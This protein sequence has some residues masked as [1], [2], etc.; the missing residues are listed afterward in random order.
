MNLLKI[1]GNT[2]ERVLRRVEEKEFASKH[3]RDLEKLKDGVMINSGD[4]KR[5]RGKKK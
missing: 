3:N 2:L 5:G 4:A 1:D